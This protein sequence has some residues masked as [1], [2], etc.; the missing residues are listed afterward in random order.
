MNMVS[1]FQSE[2]I[3]NFNFIGDDATLLQLED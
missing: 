2:L 1:I 3:F